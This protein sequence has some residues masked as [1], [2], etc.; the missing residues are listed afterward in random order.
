MFKWPEFKWPTTWRLDFWGLGQK[1][2]SL[3]KRR[4]EWLLHQL[5][6]NCCRRS[7]FKVFPFSALV[8]YS[9]LPSGFISVFFFHSR[10]FFFLYKGCFWV[11]K[12]WLFFSAPLE[13]VSQIWKEENSLKFVSSLQN[14]GKAVI[15]G[16]FQF[17]LLEIVIFSL[18]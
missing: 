9:V 8:N 15:E 7:G 11:G 14:W 16:T 18:N 10:F 13:Q 17:Q 1:K 6:Y 12:Y 3:S 5:L 4:R 2:C